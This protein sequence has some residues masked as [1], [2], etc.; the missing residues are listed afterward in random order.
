MIVDSSDKSWIT[1]VIV[2][3]AIATLLYIP[4]ARAAFAPPSGGSWAGLFYGVAGTAMMTFAGILG[5][6]KKFPTLHV[7]R[8]SLWLRG[9]VW[10][11]LL[12]VPMILFH[13]GFSLG[14]SLTTVLMI[15]F[16]TI[17]LSGIFG[18]ALQQF[19]PKLMMDTVPTEVVFEQTDGYLEHLFETA[20]QRVESLKPKPD[21]EDKA[22][23]K[24]VRE[25]YTSA[26]LP[27]LRNPKGLFAVEQRSRS[28]FD[29]VRKLVPPES[30]PVLLEL[31]KII[32]QRRDLARQTKLHRILHGWLLVHVPLSAALLVLTL[33]HMFVAL[34]HT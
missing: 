8:V 34:R 23:Y 25:F 16:A 21:A 5:A 3:G 28:L 14:G 31:N 15:V 18:V 12:S 20:E 24:I 33:V 4:Y 13:G 32:W 22:G 27:Y 29:H 2:I 6:R 9:H 17:V 1:A 10:L 30:H 19:I 11:G 7:G 26:I